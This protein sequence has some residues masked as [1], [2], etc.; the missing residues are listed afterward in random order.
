MDKRVYIKKIDVQA[1][2]IK[3]FYDKRAVKCLLGDKTRNTT[4]LLGDANPSYADDWNTFEKDFVL[5]YLNTGNECNILDIGCGVGRWAETLEPLCREYIGVDFSEQMIKAASLHFQDKSNV[6]FINNS[7]QGIFAEKDICHRKFDSV[8]IAG[9]SMYI[10]EKDLKEC[11]SRLANLLNTGA[12]VYMEESVGVRE[13]L[14]LNNIWSEAL[15]DNYAAI[16]RTKEEYLSM[17]K[18]L[19]EKCDIIEENYFN[20]LDKKEL[21]ETSHWYIIMQMK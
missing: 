7:F 5:P 9:V 21:A 3:K 4:V 12:I 16:Y 1:E 10:N 6:K 8:I 19:L 20:N 18:P 17:L 13:R 14:T 15:D 11:F 2:N